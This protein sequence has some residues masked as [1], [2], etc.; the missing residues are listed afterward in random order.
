VPVQPL[1][2]GPD[3]ARLEGIASTLRDFVRADVPQS[4]DLVREHHPRLADLQPGPAT[5][6]FELDDAQ[7]TV[8][9]MYG[10][11]S[12]PAL[13]RHVEL[14]TTLSRAPHRQAV[15]EEIADD[16]GRADELLRLACLNY[17]NDTPD[18]WESAARLLAEH[19]D[20][21]RSSIYTAAATGDV[22]AATALLTADPSAA[23]RPG[24]P[25]GWEPLLYLTYSRLVVDGAGHDHVAVARLLLDHGAD[26]NAGYL[27]EGLPSP[28]TALTGVFGGGEQGAPP[29][30]DELVLARLL[31]EA[32]AEAND[33]QTIYDRGLGDVPR[34]DTAYLE[35]LLDAGLGRGDGGPW[36]QMLGTAHAAPDDLTAEALQHAAEAGLS[37]RVQ[38]LLDRGVDPDRGGGHPLFHGRS[39]YQGAIRNGNLDIARWLADAG[40]TTD[41]VDPL[42]R[43]VGAALAP[44]P[45]QLATLL[46]A[47]D[48]LLDRARVEHPDLVA[49]AAE[50]GRADAVRLLVASGF[51]VNALAGATALHRAAWAGDVELARL[52]V[53]LGADPS[54][55]DT[56]HAGTPLGWAA[57]GGR[58][59]MVA[60]LGTVTPPA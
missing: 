13:R 11:P 50:L 30:H 26:P 15:G 46:A 37:A 39:P 2:D 43:F 12:W 23:G 49:R 19:P 35:L 31:L 56:E 5:S 55:T 58:P 22:D 53:D 20:L 6:A 34:D 3:L 4:I 60:Y 51:D 40:A 47:D 48:T 36:R 29:H 32:G 41:G 9:R 24:G 16:A 1:P 27:W 14:V 18:R 10:F 17:G 42:D 38:L 54:I 21:A 52:L 33:S 45:A 44:D 59:A 25:F 28:F 8:A 7:L 57:H